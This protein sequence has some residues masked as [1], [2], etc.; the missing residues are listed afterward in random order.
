MKNFRNE[1]KS[2]FTAID[3]SIV[4]DE[5]LTWKAKGIYLYLA[6]KPDDWRFY[7]KDIAKHAKE[8]MTSLQS[9]VKELEVKGYLERKHS[10]DQDNKFVGYVWILKANSNP[11]QPENPLDGKPVRPETPLH[12]NTNNTNTDNTNT[13]ISYQRWVDLWNQLHG[14]NYKVTKKKKEQIGA[15]LKKFTPQEIGVAITNRLQDIWLNTDGQEYLPRWEAFW[16]SDDKVDR[17]LNQ[18]QKEDELPF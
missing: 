17:Y 1:V 8:G 11:R 14:T 3:N 9:G 2:N 4:N 15:R 12:T 13:N 5:T 6:S 10:F 16:R 18:S 7:M